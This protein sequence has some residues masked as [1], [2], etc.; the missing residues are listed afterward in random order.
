MTIHTSGETVNKKG[1]VTD[2]ATKK[3]GKIKFL[4]TQIK[5]KASGRKSDYS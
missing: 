3:E 5:K 1:T 2:T 4:K